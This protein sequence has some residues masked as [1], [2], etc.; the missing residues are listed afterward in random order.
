MEKGSFDYY[1][2]ELDA[3]DIDHKSRKELAELYKVATLISGPTGQKAWHELWLYGT[4]LVLKICNKLRKENLLRMDFEDAVA[5]GNLAIG[6]AL[7]RWQPAKAAF[8]TWIWIRIRGA[9]LD[10]ERKEAKGG[11][12]G[13]V[14]EAPRVVSTQSSN[15]N[16][17]D[18]G[19]SE[20][21]ITDQFE[22]GQTPDGGVEA[23]ERQELYT[24]ILKLAPREQQYIN[25][26]YFED[27]P[28]AEIA[29]MEGISHQMVRKILARAIDKLGEGLNIPRS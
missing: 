12:V 28:I 4:K 21:T 14:E 18:A 11:M 5:E 3:T 16:T 29:A 10:G 8:G 17:D 25:A 23:M 2:A 19:G 6:E 26:I 7:T 24:E 9:V 15:A 27:R 1:S 13:P 22:T 20:Y